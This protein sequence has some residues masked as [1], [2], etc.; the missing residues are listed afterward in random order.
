MRWLLNRNGIATRTLVI[1]IVGIIVIA[2]IAGAAYYVTLPGP[3][4]TPATPT[5]ATPTPATPTPATP[6]P[7]T[8]TPATPTPATP[9]PATPTPATPTPATPTPQKV[10]LKMGG[11]THLSGAYAADGKRVQIIYSSLAD[12]INSKGG[13]YLKAVNTYAF[14]DLRFY[15]GE[16][17][18]ARYV[19]L[20]TK[21]VTEKEVDILLCAGSPSAILS[22]AVLNIEKAGGVPEIDACLLD[23]IV[24]LKKDCP[25]GKFIWSWHMDSFAIDEATLVSKLVTKYR[26]ET[27]GVA[28][29]LFVDDASGRAT[30]SLIGPKIEEA[31]YN[32]IDPGLIPPGTTDFTS[33]IA[34][35]NEAGVEVVYSHVSP[36]MFVSFWRQCVGLGF[37]PK[38][39]G[40]SQRTLR[41]PELAALGDIANNLVGHVLWTPVMPFPGNDWFTSNWEKLSGGL[42]LL[43]MEGTIYDAF[44]AAIKAVEAAGK[45][46]AQAINDE[47][48]KL[49]FMSCT[50]RVSF[51]QDNHACHI[52]SPA[53]LQYKIT[54]E[55]KIDSKIVITLP[56]SGVPENPLTLLR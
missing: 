17:Q 12:G 50:G 9:T 14:I 54:A 55:G 56:G 45:I 15:D 16:S 42:P 47:I 2:I 29:L 22:A 20:A 53:L 34:K 8:P 36:D 4:P 5:P 48:A 44:M 13:I 30:R 27:N 28:G 23:P 3:T 51:D 25:G 11:L 21:I 39:C 7:A 24:A 38:I 32:C 31:N 37:K 40:A 35:F 43:G 33:V 1:A 52:Q 19:E 49:D 6:T 18:A 46:E 41:P 10:K 26:T